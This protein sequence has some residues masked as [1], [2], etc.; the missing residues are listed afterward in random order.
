MIDRRDI[1]VGSAT[2]VAASLLAPSKPALA[3]ATTVP[4]TKRGFLDG[5]WIASAL[6]AS[7]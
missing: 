5:L 3:Q 7:Q 1:L 6:R 2:A 4:G